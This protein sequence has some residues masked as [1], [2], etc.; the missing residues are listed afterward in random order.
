[1]RDSIFYSAI[2]ALVASFSIVIGLCLGFIFISVLISALAGTTTEPK[3]TTVNTE[4]ILPNAKGKRESFSGDTPVILQIN[5]DGVIGTEALDEK[6]VRQILVESREGNLKNNLV[7]GILL[8]INSPGGTVTDADGIYRLIMDYKTKYNIPVYAFVDGL[9]ASGGVYVSLAADKVFSTDS[10]LIGS[11]GVLIP[12]FM[13]FNKLLDKFGIDTVTVT[14][15]KDKDAMNPLRPWKEDEAKNYREIVNFYYNNFVDLVTKHRT[16]INKETL[17]KEYGAQI[18][19]APEALSFGF[20]DV[21]GVSLSATLEELVKVAN[22]K[23]DNYRVIRLSHKGWWN[24]L[25]SS[26]APFFFTGKV[27]HQLTVNPE[28][29]MLLQNKFLYLY[30]P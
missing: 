9:C 23:E 14:A 18:F 26:Q 29:D 28:I 22:I 13:N 3:L 4:E 21:S 30:Y 25:F 2:R 1:M 15:G 12:T 10:S 11:V 19:P 8:Y 24:T 20:I 6:S 16:K 17:I 5:I 27:H 7:K